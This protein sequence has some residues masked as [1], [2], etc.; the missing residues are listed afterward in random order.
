MKK[1]AIG[2]A[3]AMTL[4]LTAL[5]GSV[6]AMPAQAAGIESRATDFSAQ[7]MMEDRRMMRRP[8]MRRGPVCT[9]RTEVRRGP[10]GRRIVS[11]TKV[12]R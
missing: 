9:V 4:G 2:F 7:R 11:K 8:M 12:C 1:L 10:M 6:S 3:A 5:A